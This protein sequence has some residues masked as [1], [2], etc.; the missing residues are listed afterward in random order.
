LKAKPSASLSGFQRRWASGEAA[1]EEEAPISKLQ[2]TPQEEVEN[3]IHEDEAKPETTEA[4]AEASSTEAVVQDI[5]E[6]A[7]A[8]ETAAVDADVEATPIPSEPPAP[9]SQGGWSPG[10]RASHLDESPADKMKRI[11]EPKR[12]VYI[13]NLFFDVTE[14]DLKKELIRFGPIEQLR[15]LRDGRG[16]SKG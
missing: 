3:A 4:E 10:P 12:T 1:A 11:A 13:G 5:V 6:D 2:P 16:L 8:S 7:P 14:D 9:E 15:L